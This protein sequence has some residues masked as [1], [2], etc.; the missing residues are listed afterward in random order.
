MQSSLR[1]AVGVRWH[2]RCL[3]YGPWIVIVIWLICWYY[4]NNDRLVHTARQRLLHGEPTC[5]AP[6]DAGLGRAVCQLQLRFHAQWAALD[7][8]IIW[9]LCLRWKETGW[10]ITKYGNQW[11]PLAISSTLW[12]GLPPRTATSCHQIPS[13][14]VVW[15]PR[16]GYAAL[17]LRETCCYKAGG[18][19]QG[20]NAVPWKEMLLASILM[21]FSILN[22]P[23]W[24]PPH[25]KRQP[26]G[27]LGFSHM[28]IRLPRQA[29]GHECS[30][31]FV[32]RFARMWAT[33]CHNPTI[34][35]W[36]I[37]VYHP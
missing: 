23:F 6:S 12:L 22:P 29:L 16:W 4:D 2:G 30:E 28:F 31:V 9:G 25:F 5:T 35:R 8:D 18:L 11:S 32:Y 7:S 21:G 20:Q 33:Q 10:P 3:R 19:S 14:S 15:S 13:G 27:R 36:A 26:R 37:P 17:G 34:W 24:G 1:M